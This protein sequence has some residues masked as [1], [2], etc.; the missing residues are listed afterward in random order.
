LL[1]LVPYPFTTEKASSSLLLE[2]VVDLADFFPG[3]D[4]NDAT[5]VVYHSSSQQI[6][7]HNP[8]RAEQRFIPAS[9]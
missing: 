7:R 9:T 8:A 2:S 5:F 1:P 3:I 6:I 4:P